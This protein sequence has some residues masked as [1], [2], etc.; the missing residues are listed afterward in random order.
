M[1]KIAY[2]GQPICPEC[3]MPMSQIWPSDKWVCPHCIG[4]K[5]AQEA[6]KKLTLDLKDIA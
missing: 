1:K 5:M 4:R 2:I 6:S 3:K